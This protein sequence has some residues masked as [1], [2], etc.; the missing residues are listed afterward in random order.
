MDLNSLSQIIENGIKKM[1]LDPIT[2]RTGSDDNW[3][4]QKGSASISIN[5]EV[6]NKFPDGYFSVSS[7]LMDLTHV[8]EIDKEKFFRKLLELN[9]TL[10][11]MQLTLKN[12]KIILMSNR[13]AEGLDE[14][15]VALTINE[16]SFYADDMDD[17]LLNYIS[18]L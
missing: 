11:G 16:L 9:S 13:F 10:V 18:D 4:T 2:M 1:K 12:D 14:T 6:S 3:I 15:E 17:F 5:A 7:I 8:K